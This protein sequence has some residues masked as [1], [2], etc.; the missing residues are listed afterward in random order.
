MKN[1]LRLYLVFLWLV[2][3]L[4]NTSSLLNLLWC[5]FWVVML[6]DKNGDE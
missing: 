4:F 5:I 1:F 6:L 3:L 2:S